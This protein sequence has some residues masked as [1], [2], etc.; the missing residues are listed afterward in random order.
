MCALLVAFVPPSIVPGGSRAAVRMQMPEMPKMPKID[1]KDFLGGIEIEA[2]GDKFAAPGDLK[3]IP[4]DVQFSD[5][6]G[7]TITLRGVPGRK[8]DYYVGKDLKLS[9]AVLTANGGSLQVTGTVKKGTPLSFLGFNME[10][11]I[12]DQMTPQ[13]PEDLSRA[14]ALVN[15]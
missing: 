11:T 13:D 12:T 5:V 1:F 6:D 9:G 3:L 2:F 7:D 15:D 4:S 10:E 14:M 8:V